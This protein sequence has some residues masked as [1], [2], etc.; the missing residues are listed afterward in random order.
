MKIHVGTEVW[1]RNWKGPKNR[2]DVQMRQN[3]GKSLT[4]TNARRGK[5]LGDG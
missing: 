4:V 2:D 1:K 3:K 5:L